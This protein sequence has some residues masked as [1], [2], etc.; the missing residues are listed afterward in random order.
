MSTTP[1]DPKRPTETEL[2]AADFARLL[3]TGETLSTCSCKVVL[4][5][6][7]AETDIV[8][9]K[10]GSASITGT[11][12]VQKVTGGTDGVTYM[13]IF[14]AVTS[15]GQT[16]DLTRDLPVQRDQT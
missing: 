13:L 5:D 4:A 3:G 16:L 15:A 1:F 6:D 7:A 8:A 10:T 9:M 11:K 2:F 12:V 14:Q